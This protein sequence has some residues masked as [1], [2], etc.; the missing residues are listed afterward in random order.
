MLA[1]RG[2]F[3]LSA[4]L[5]PG[6]LEPFPSLR[7]YGCMPTTAFSAIAN[8]LVTFLGGANVSLTPLEKGERTP[9]PENRREILIRVTIDKV[10]YLFRA[11][12]ESLAFTTTE[13]GFLNE[14]M[15]AFEGLFGGFSAQGYAA[16]FRTALLTSLTDIAVARYIRGDRKGVFWPVQSLLQLLKNLSY[17][18]YEGTAATTGFL[19]YRT[20]LDDF[21]GAL[22]K[23]PYAWFDLGKERQRISG[24]FFRNPLSYRFVDGQRSL[25]VC[26]IRTNVKGTIETRS[27]R[28]RKS[29]EQLAHRD[30]LAL[31][32]MAG[33]GAFA[34]YVNESS[35]V[36]VVLD[37]D[38][39]LVWRKGAWAI[40][41]PDIFREFLSG[42]L[43]KRSIDYLVWAVYALSK[44]RHG[45]VVLIANDDTDLD[46]LRKGSV[47]GRDPVSRALVEHVRGKKIGT[48]KRTGELIRILSSDGLTVINRKGELLDTGVII[49]TSQVNDLV[50]GGGRT[51]AATAASHFGRVVK[52]SEDGP[53]E[54]FRDGRRVYQFG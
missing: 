12:R 36:E 35:E 39:L 6:L 5:S 40:Y 53:V 31:L 30:T 29:I 18:R 27:P 11:R 42:H 3:G 46:Q 14:L 44:A 20:Q 24:N 33:E 17:Q 23:S 48:L 51:T 54:L 32:E 41:D 25:F 2:F 10:S 47:G 37:Q 13:E 38:R 28:P 45:T 43:E 50:T 15:A 4:D 16:H 34:I 26:D 22:S 52:V 19:V 21:L 7:H 1:C 8:S 49:D 9:D